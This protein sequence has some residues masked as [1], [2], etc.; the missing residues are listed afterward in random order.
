MKCNIDIYPL[1]VES[2]QD[3]EKVMGP[4]G[5][6][7]GCWC[8]FWREKRKDF[9]KNCGEPNRL[10]MLRLV[11]SGITPG[12]IAYRNE[13]PIGW[14]SVA[15]RAQFSSLN[16][17]PIYKPIDKQS[18]WSIVCFYIPKP[19]RMQGLLKDLIIGAVRFSASQ[20]AE[21]IEA[22]P[23]EVKEKREPVDL[24]RG[25]YSIFVELGFRE[26]LR[27]KPNRP[28]LRYDIPLQLHANTIN[29]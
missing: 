18:V 12:I 22:Y 19:F 29:T 7:G 23:V 21:I 16:R 2:W 1:S 26:I 20:R 28:I 6:Y 27:R 10:A 17:A 5:A 9:E 4:Q 14:C 15:P 3:F 24:Y 13:E 25:L 8:M 11:E